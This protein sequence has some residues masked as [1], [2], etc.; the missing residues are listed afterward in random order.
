[1][2]SGGVDGKSAMRIPGDGNQANKT[3]KFTGDRGRWP[4][5]ETRCEKPDGRSKRMAVWSA[6]KSIDRTARFSFKA[7]IALNAG[8]QSPAQVGSEERER[9]IGQPN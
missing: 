7:A 4:K 3:T 8:Q 5:M 9:K 2:L 1:M 6:D